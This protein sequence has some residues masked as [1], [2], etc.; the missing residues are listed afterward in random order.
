MNELHLF[1]GAGG[2]ILGGMLLGHTCMC[3]V[4]L[5][6]FARGVLLDRQRDGILPR[7]PIWD[8]IKT[9]DGTPWRGTVDLVAGGFPCTNISTA[10]L[11]EG[12]EGAESGLWSEMARIIGE[13]RPRYVFVENSPSLFTRG[14]DVV[15]GSLAAMGFDAEWGVVG[16][17]SLGGPIVRERAWVLGADRS[18]LLRGPEGQRQLTQEQ[19][20]QRTALVGA[21]AA[22]TDRWGTFPELPGM[23]GRVAHR[24]D[25]QRCA[26]NAQV[27]VV[28]AATHQILRRRLAEI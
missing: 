28:A 6:P 12:I 1:A 8:D 7:F 5:D 18:R 25:R 16:A 19:A 17:N 27:P 24:V 3:A 9:F 23:V 26:G 14:I 11:K 21:I 15:L 20:G 13:V 2:G 10:G 4:E 22:G